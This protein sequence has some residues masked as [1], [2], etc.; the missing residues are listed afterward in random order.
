MAR[1]IKY[2]RKMCSKF[3]IIIQIQYSSIVIASRDNN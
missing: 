2:N 1:V 3:V